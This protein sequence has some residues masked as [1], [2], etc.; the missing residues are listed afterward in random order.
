MFSTAHAAIAFVVQLKCRACPLYKQL[1]DLFL[2]WP[3]LTKGTMFQST[4]PSGIDASL[5]YAPSM[6]SSEYGSAK[7]TYMRTSIRFISNS[8]SAR[9]ACLEMVVIV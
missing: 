5:W 9:T 6:S 3:T 7:S 8:S 4:G 1:A 2:S